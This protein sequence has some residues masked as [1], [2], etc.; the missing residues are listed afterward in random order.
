[1]DS[2]L[3]CLASGMDD[4]MSKPVDI[5]QLDERIRTWTAS[6][7]DEACTT[8]PMPCRP[9]QD[10]VLSV[11]REGPVQ[12][13]VKGRRQGVKN[14]LDGAVAEDEWAALWAGRRGRLSHLDLE[15]SNC[16][17]GDGKKMLQNIAVQDML[18]V[19]WGHLCHLI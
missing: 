5:R 11:S 10:S 16:K 4:Y 2:L 18:C 13:S 14:C 7:A 8:V 15:V 19:R 6:S 9:L 3:Q 17:G 12:G 1:M